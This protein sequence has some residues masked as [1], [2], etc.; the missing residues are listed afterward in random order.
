MIGNRYEIGS[1]I[2]RGAMGE[3]YRGRDTQ[4]GDDV[5]IKSL[6]A[7]LIASTPDL[8]ARFEREGN[9]LRKLNHPNI[10]TTMDNY[11]AAGGHYIVMEYVSGGSLRDLIRN[12]SP[13][14]IKRVLE[15]ALEISDALARVHR[16]GIIHRDIKP[17]NVLIAEDGTPRLTDFGVAHVSDDTRLTQTGFVFGTY[18]YVSPEA[19]YGQPLDARADIWSFGVMLFEMLTG[20]LPFQGTT[21]ATIITAILKDPVPDVREW[22]SDVP[23]ALADLLQRMMQKDVA[24]RLDSARQIGAVLEAVLHGQP[25]PLTPMPATQQIIISTPSRKFIEGPRHNLPPQP[26]PFV[27]RAQEI[28]EII[29]TLNDPN[30]RLLT[31]LGSGGIGKTRLALEVASRK[32]D[33][34]ANG[35]FFVA[36]APITAPDFVLAAV[37]D[38]LQFTFFGDATGHRQQLFDFLREKELLLVM[39]NFEHLMNASDL[40]S[41]ILAMAPRIKI[42]VTSRE[43][44][45]MQEEWVRR[46]QGMAFPEVTDTA[47]F[48]AYS[49]VQLF[50]ESARRV[51]ADF[52]VEVERECILNVLKLV[53]GMPLAIELATAW[54]RM[55]T[56][57]QVVDEIH[58]NLDFLATNLRN[59]PE[60][61][62][63]LRAVFDYSWQM[64]DAHEQ[65]VL[66]RL[67]A[68]QGGFNREA[69]KTIAGASF[70]DIS[71]LIDKSLLQQVGPNRY[72]M[73]LLVRQYADEQ[74]SADSVLADDMAAAHARYFLGWLADQEPALK[75]S[76]Q[77]AALHAIDKDIDN[78]RAAWGWAMQHVDYALVGKALVALYL[79]YMQR[80]WYN[81]A[82]E[83]FQAA[84]DALAMDEPAGPRGLVYGHVLS[85]Y[86]A[87]ATLPPEK[88]REMLILAQQILEDLG[89][90]RDLKMIYHL[91]GSI[92]PD[93]DE[94][95]HLLHESLAISNETNDEW[96]VM[97]TLNAL[98]NI[99]WAKGDAQQA[100]TTYY[101]S[102]EIGKRLG[103]Q[104]EMAYV[105]NALG[106]VGWVTGEYDE[107]REA[108]ECALEIVQLFNSRFQI[109]LIAYNLGDV[110]FDMGD[111][112]AAQSRYEFA[113]RLAQEMGTVFMELH[114]YGRLGDLARLRGDAAEAMKFYRRGFALADRSPNHQPPLVLRVGMGL[115]ALELGNFDQ[116]RNY[117]D[118]AV[119]TTVRYRAV[120]FMSDAL[121]PRA[122]LAVAEKDYALAADIVQVL[123]HESGV[124]MEVVKGA[125]AVLGAIREQLEPAT[126][127]VI[128]S[129]TDRLD[130]AA[131]VARIIGE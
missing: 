79:F 47:G 75:G 100:R 62:R 111:F 39:D 21:P 104:L 116:A 64:M 96:G 19:C 30:C 15:I 34:Y 78:V 66:R 57:D 103:N 48:M 109:G 83:A 86:G 44:L 25:T 122:Q 110:L 72:D 95:L 63:S 37:A 40:L 88:R 46:V 53:N 108:Y 27:G 6:K 8:V 89:S 10:V 20:E 98:G 90:H 60:R 69:A 87:A 16:L 14:P 56:C 31:L 93:R 71:G 82:G 52:D 2:G 81:E 35:V 92:N 101:E 12:Q 26:T 84:A 114:C 38:A 94:T 112:A 11:S 125:R 13:L 50:V 58:D 118:G 59:V 7:E 105:Y 49:A 3:V 43:A 99:H 76:G 80:N 5:A 126:V 97:I 77:K 36:L 29:N 70:M 106:N 67:S 65:D 119:E 127:A 130:V 129:G 115:M 124:R 61:H 121:L 123:L 120:A 9:V 32:M 128:E 17:A 28:G 18:A 91:I 51:R 102:L 131:L 1:L 22:R 33:D 68:F 24:D 55:M 4:T 107:A 42:L 73:H 113:F 23:D 41:D 74:L 45:N 85:F 117:L 54:L